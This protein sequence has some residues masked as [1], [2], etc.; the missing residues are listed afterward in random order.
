MATI[1]T[2]ITYAF[3][4]LNREELVAIPTE[5]VY[6]LAGNAFNAL[7][8]AK[9]FKVKERPSF[10]PLIV[11]TSDLER[12][13]E[14]V[15]DIPEK[16]YDLAT[17]FWPGPLTMVFKKKAIIPDLVTSG[18]DTVAVRIPKHALTLELLKSIDF[19]LAAPSANPFGYV[20]PTQATHVN[21]QLGAKIPYILD[22]GPCQVGVESTIVGFHGDE[23]TVL[24]LG[25]CKV[26]DI[27]RIVGKINIRLHAS[28]N[29]VAPG[30]LDS[31]Y[32]PLT[33]VRIGNIE[34]LIAQ[35]QGKRIGVL[36]FDRYYDG[37]DPINQFVLSKKGDL[38]EAATCLF[39][40]LRQLDMLNL[41][42]II[43]EYVQDIG[44]GRAINDRLRRAEAKRN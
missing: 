17:A 29:P 11:H 19:P 23:A 22:G 8:V 32:A 40:G 41:Q 20:S 15:V 38:D 5:T 43:S 44:L 21:E 26:E 14:F 25:G 16:A 2:D 10:D 39:T 42:L 24:R 12:I 6:G 27:E 37:I 13:H 30:M 4:L 28:S 31:H 7:S 33:P 18:L 34:E 35:Y 9:I 1:G 36:S 3:E